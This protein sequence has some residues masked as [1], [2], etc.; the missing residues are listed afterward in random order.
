MVQRE[1]SPQIHR[2]LWFHDANQTVLYVATEGEESPIFTNYLSNVHFEV[3]MGS[4][5]IATMDMYAEVQE[6]DVVSVI[7]ATPYRYGGNLEALITVQPGM[8]LD[9]VSINGGKLNDNGKRIR[10]KI[11]RIERKD[12][13]WRNLQETFGPQAE[14][15]KLLLEMM[16]QDN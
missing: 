3:V 5:Y 7:R 8:N 14:V 11:N 1:T 15:S 16:R 9:T 13:F 12:A 4:G 10:R 2:E 6:G